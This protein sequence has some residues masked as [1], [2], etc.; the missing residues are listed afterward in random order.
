MNMS[1][2]LENCL[3]L[4]ISEYCRNNY[5][6]VIGDLLKCSNL[7]S[8]KELAPKIIPRYLPK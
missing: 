2:N 7:Q 8:V 1:L 3:K 6:L 4:N 5:S